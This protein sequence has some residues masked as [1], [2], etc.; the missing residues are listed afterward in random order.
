[1]AAFTQVVEAVRQAAEPAPISEAHQRIGPTGRVLPGI[2]ELTGESAERLA[3]YSELDAP[4][5]PAEQPLRA[6]EVEVARYRW[7]PELAATVA[8]R[9]YLHPVRTLGG[10]VVSESG[11][12][13]HL[14]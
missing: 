14:H 13:D 11:P 1:M 10:V 8:P 3:L 12:A 2:T 4:W 5:A 7:R 6:G 9:P